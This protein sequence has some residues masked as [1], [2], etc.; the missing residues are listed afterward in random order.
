MPG[1]HGSPRWAT[2]IQGYRNETPHDLAV[3]E[4]GHFAVLGRSDSDSLDVV[5][6]PG[7]YTQTA[8]QYYV[9]QMNADTGTW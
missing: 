4:Q 5:P 7:E 1:P 6:G 2:L 9:V 3:S 8:L